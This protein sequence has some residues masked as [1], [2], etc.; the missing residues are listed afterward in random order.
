M[1]GM[2]RV[3]FMIMRLSGSYSLFVAHFV[4]GANQEA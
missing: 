4:S 2:T 1:P 3:H